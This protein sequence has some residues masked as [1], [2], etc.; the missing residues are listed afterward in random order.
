MVEKNTTLKAKLGSPLGERRSRYVIAKAIPR[1]GQLSR[2]WRDLKLGFEYLLIIVVAWTQH[3]PV[4]AKRDRLVVAVG[5]NV[6]DIENRHSRSI[7]TDMPMACIS[8]AKYRTYFLFSG[9]E[10]R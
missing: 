3:H 10:S 4:L 6:S 7:I 2:L 5:R 1:P 8:R 9:A